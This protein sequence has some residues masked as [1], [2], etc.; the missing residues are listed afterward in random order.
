M[1]CTWQ[2]PD[3]KT[4]NTAWMKMF[5]TPADSEATCGFS[6]AVSTS[7][8][9]STNLHCVMQVNQ[10]TT[11]HQPRASRR[12]QKDHETHSENSPTIQAAAKSTSVMALLPRPCASPIR[13][14]L[15]RR[16]T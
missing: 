9:S 4:L 14:P 7:T 13:R 3:E 12:D 16:S 6:R 5:C 1:Y 15:S 2:S 8:C 11:T 10:S